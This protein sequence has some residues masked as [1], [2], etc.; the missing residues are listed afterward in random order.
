MRLIKIAR[1]QFLDYELV[2]V[3]RHLCYLVSEIFHRLNYMLLKTNKIPG[4]GT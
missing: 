3:D 1:C 4:Q 2:R